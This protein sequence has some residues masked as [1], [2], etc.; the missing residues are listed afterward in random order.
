[1]DIDEMGTREVKKRLR[2]AGCKERPGKGSHTKVKCPPDKLTV[3]PDNREF[4]KGTLK[5]IEKQSG[6][7]MKEGLLR[8][9]IR[10]SIA[11]ATIHALKR[12]EREISKKMDSDGKPAQKPTKILPEEGKQ[13]LFDAVKLIGPHMTKSMYDRMK[14]IPR[15]RLERSFGNRIHS[16]RFG[17]RNRKNA[18]TNAKAAL[19][20]AILYL[21]DKGDEIVNRELNRYLSDRINSDVN[22]QKSRMDSPWKS[23]EMNYKETT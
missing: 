19:A 23:G 1:M 3:V 18:M 14:M 9:L 5:A 17:M 13:G 10:E 20:K 22:H 2:K 11:A 12:R 15:D 21:G 6:V 16:Y 4:S 7:K 8:D